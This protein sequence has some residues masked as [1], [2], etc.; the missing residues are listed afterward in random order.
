MMQSRIAHEQFSLSARPGYGRDVATDREDELDKDCLSYLKSIQGR[1][2]HPLVIDIGGGNGAMSVKMAQYG[3]YV[4]LV[5][6][7][8]KPLH[9]DQYKDSCIR[10]I[11][12]EIEAIEEKDILGISESHKLDIVYSQRM[13]HYLPYCRA[14]EIL[15]KLHDDYVINF[16]KI[17]LSI[18]GLESALGENYTGQNFPIDSSSRHVIPV[19]TEAKHLGICEPVTLYT[20]EEAEQLMRESG[21]QNIKITKS[22]YGTLK[23]IADYTSSK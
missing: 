6:P 17:F 20:Q 10:H 5:D 23:V 12:K 13:M 11:S 16:C 7:I 22:V 18:T 2:I 3:A 4:T 1:F 15:Q 19:N 14:V 8:L 9:I 21:Y